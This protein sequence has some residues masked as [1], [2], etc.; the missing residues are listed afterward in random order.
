LLADDQP[1][2]RD[3]IHN[4]LDREED[5]SVVGEAANGEETIRQVRRSR[6]D[7]VLLDVAMPGPGP[8]SVI[9]AL[10]PR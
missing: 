7:V 5:F 1:V 2:V 10:R 8:V 3:G 4:R 6:P 9:K